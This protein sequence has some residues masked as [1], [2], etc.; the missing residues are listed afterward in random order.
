ML[1]V[2]VPCKGLRGLAHPIQTRCYKQKIFVHNENRFKVLYIPQSMGM[3]R[4]W[5][6]SPYIG[7]YWVVLGLYGAICGYLRRYWVYL[8]WYARLTFI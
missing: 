3:L 1:F 5:A 6:I 4:K 2:V 8:G 7:L